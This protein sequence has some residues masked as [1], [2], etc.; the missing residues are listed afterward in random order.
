VTQV[1]LPKIRR[2]V[3]GD[4][5]LARLVA[6]PGP[7]AVTVYRGEVSARSRWPQVSPSVDPPLLPNQPAAAG[8]IGPY[9]VVFDGT[10]ST[11]LEVGLARCGEQLRWSPQTTVAAGTVEDCLQAVDRVSA[12]LRDWQA[13]LEGVSSALLVPPPGFDPGPP[14][15]DRNT[16]PVRW[17]VPLQ[18]QLD[19]TT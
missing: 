1:Q 3:L 18:W 8:L 5:L 19:L 16:K 2:K 11:D 7:V 17:F 15:P 9:V 14:R 13:V 4:Q 6:L 12:W 10:G